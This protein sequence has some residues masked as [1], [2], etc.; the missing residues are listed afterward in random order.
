MT[1]LSMLPD[2]C[3][4]VVLGNR[5][6]QYRT[7]GDLV[8]IDTLLTKNIKDLK[9]TTF[10]NGGRHNVAYFSIVPNTK[11]IGV[12]IN[13]NSFETE[14]RELVTIKKEIHFDE[15]SMHFGKVWTTTFD[16]PISEERY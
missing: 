4:V 1:E 7:E 9:V 13:Y 8:G 11:R 3:N 15:Y 14:M 12:Y 5:G 2:H 6:Y 16:Y 10:V